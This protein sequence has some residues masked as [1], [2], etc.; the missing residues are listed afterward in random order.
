MNYF[1]V[2]VLLLRQI[3]HSLCS[4][5][6]II[7]S[8]DCISQVALV[9]TLSAAGLVGAPAHHGQVALLPLGLLPDL[10]TARIAVPRWLW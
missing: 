8:Q 7:H 2:L 4:W 9:A 1:G 3:C 6:L 5:I 10:H